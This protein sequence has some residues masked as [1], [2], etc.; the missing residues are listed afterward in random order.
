MHDPF[1]VDHGEA[2]AG[3]QCGIIALLGRAAPNAQ[4]AA[5]Y[6]FKLLC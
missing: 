3:L 2:L 1:S 4:P 6:S 5:R